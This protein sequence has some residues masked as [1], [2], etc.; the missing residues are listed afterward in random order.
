MALEATAAGSAEAAAPAARVGTV[1]PVGT[2]VRTCR[3]CGGVVDADGW[4]TVC[5]A[6][7]P[8]PRDHVVVDAGD[9]VGGV[10]DRGR[11]HHRNE[12][13]VALHT[14]TGDTAGAPTVLVVCDGVSTSPDSD[15]ASLAAAEAAVRTAVEHL[16]AGAWAREATEDALVA[17][18]T[19]ADHA[20]AATAEG[21]PGTADGPPSCTLAAA[22]VGPGEVVAAS[23]GDSRVYWLPDRGPAVQLTRDDSW[24]AE[25]LEA[26]ADR[27]LVEASPHAHAITRWL[28][29]DSPDP[30]PRLSSL[31]LDGPGWVL[32]C[33]DGLW[34]YAPTPADV[35][36]VVDEHRAD[37]DATRLAEA[38]VAWANAQGGR[39]NITVALARVGSG[40][41]T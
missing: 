41:T 36:R 28:G 20:V 32:A 38:L 15:V 27:A 11:R 37:A 33:S 7:A 13:A 40:G 8:R 2:S 4:C 14:G 3:E 26:G 22:V 5:G 30:S 6:A 17:A 25:Q 29:A 12:D 31:A 19:A 21:A 18:V 34:N 9:G 16:A 10:S 23:V 1:A 24:A 35:R 39:D